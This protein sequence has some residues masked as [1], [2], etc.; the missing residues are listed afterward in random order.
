M[1]HLT[2]DRAPI[3][4]LVTL[5]LALLTSSL[6][7][8]DTPARQSER[9]AL[10]AYAAEQFRAS[11]N[12]CET[13]SKV[14]SFAVSKANNVGDLLEDLKLVLIGEDWARRPLRRGAYYVGIRTSDSGF[15][16]ELR[17]ASPQV[18][19]AMAGIYLAKHIQPGGVGFWGTVGELVQ[20]LGNREKPNAADMLL[21]GYAE[22]LGGR[23]MNANM[24][25][26]PS[27]LS[28][29][30]CDQELRQASRPAS[31]V[32][33][34]RVFYDG[35]ENGNTNLWAQDGY[36]NRC[37]IVTSATDGVAGPY[38]GSRMARCNWNGS[39]TWN[40]PG[41]FETLAIS[42]VTYNNELF[43][44]IRVRVDK[45]LE[46]TS[47][48]PTKILRIDSGTSPQNETYFTLN[49]NA[50]CSNSIRIGGV[51]QL[52][53]WG[54][55][56]QCS[57]PSKWHRIE[58]YFNVGTGNV[59]Q[60]VDG[61]LVRNVTS[62]FNGAKWLPFYLT[63]NWSDTHNAVNHVYFD[64]IEVFSDTGSGATGSMADASVT[65][66]GTTTSVAV[67]ASIRVVPDE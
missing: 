65:A 28:K 23:L 60:W 43:F 45:N 67:P 8:A 18:E 21:Y 15:R 48:S 25:A 55:S 57:E 46:K 66:G 56:D 39:V 29:T 5:V 62:N 10:K 16:K 36:R 63:S 26:F 33:A 14:A 49:P 7:I 32:S 2:T 58:M 3:L 6:V 51:D 27:A 42:S 38:A 35:F 20:A 40:D 9:L 44:R 13:F 22:D 53:Y 1:K 37:Q 61:T 34:G 31:S 41:S 19:H 4:I 12:H 30:L 64:E 52:Y 50:S 54:S 11:N 17:D 59:K 47:Q 24:D